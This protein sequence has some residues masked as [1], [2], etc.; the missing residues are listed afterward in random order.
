MSIGDPIEV[1][2]IGVGIKKGNV[3]LLNIIG[4]SVFH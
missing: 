4:K 1:I 2:S 3:F